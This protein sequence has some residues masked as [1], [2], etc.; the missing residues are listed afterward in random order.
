MENYETKSERI[1]LYIDLNNLFLWLVSLTLLALF[2]MAWLPGYLGMQTSEIIV[3][4]IS[5]G[6]CDPIT[7]GIGFHCFGDYYYPLNFIHINNPWDIVGAPPYSAATLLIFAFFNQLSTFFDNESLGLKV[8]LAI[9]PVIMILL[10]IRSFKKFKYPFVYALLTFALTISSTPFLFAFDRG[11]LIILSLPLM[12]ILIKSY[13]EENDF[14]FLLT[15]I[16]L[17]FIKPQLVIFLLMLIVRK[18]IARFLLFGVITLFVNLIPFYFL[19]PYMFANIKSYLKVSANFQDYALPGLLVPN[20]SAPN[21]I[22]IL[23]RFIFSIPS[24]EISYISSIIPALFLIMLI[25]HL[26]IR[27]KKFDPLHNFLIII[28]YV[29]LAPNVSYQYYLILLLGFFVYAL[30]SHLELGSKFDNSKN[31]ILFFGIFSKRNRA[32][33]LTSYILLFIPWAIPWFLIIPEYTFQNQGEFG[34]SLVR[35]PGQIILFV[36]FISIML[37]RKNLNKSNSL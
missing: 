8:F 28:L 35:L 18:K 19:D 16:A 15:L 34:V 20:L 11:N 31:R 30:L 29:I 22:A 37:T 26:W 32:L 36:L 24:S 4:P 12:I 13:V 9:T 7:Q 6:H 2:V 1:D 25:L 23:E 33:I 27:G 3:G 21:S 14:N 10:C 5:D 17:T